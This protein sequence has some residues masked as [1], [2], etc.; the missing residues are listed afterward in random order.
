MNKLKEK[1]LSLFGVQFQ[2]D[3]SV[4]NGNSSGG[5]TDSFNHY[6]YV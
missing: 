5:T 1:I 2:G 3:R 4:I 6:G